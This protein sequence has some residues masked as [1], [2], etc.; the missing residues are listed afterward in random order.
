VSSSGQPSRITSGSATAEVLSD[1][2]PRRADLRL[3]V[4]ALVAWAAAAALLS[5]PASWVAVVVALLTGAALWLLRPSR[6]ARLGRPRAR[7]SGGAGVP[8]MLVATALVLVS[9]V[10]HR[11]LRTAGPVVD[12][13][14]QGASVTLRAEVVSDPRLLPARGVRRTPLVIVGLQVDQIVGR[15]NR[16]R[17]SAPVLAF[18]DPSWLGLQ[19]GEQVEVRGRLAPAQPG[20]DVVATLNGKGSPVV[21]AP[22]SAMKRAAGRLRAGLR[23][24]VRGTPS[25]GAG[26]LPGL[27]VGDT[28]GL[29]PGL[30][31][32]MRSSGLTHL[33]AVS[34]SNVAIVCGSAL[35]LAQRLGLPRRL[36]PPLA[37]LTLVGFVIVARPEPSVLRAAVMGGIGL[38]GLATARGRHGVPAL[39]AAIIALLVVDPWLA[40]SY[41]FALSSLATLGLLLFARPWGEAL[42]RWLPRPVAFAVAVPL[43]A[44][45]ACGPVIVLLQ[46]SV[47][48]VSVPANLVV[49]PLVAPATIAGV[50]AAASSL[51]SSHLAHLIAWLGVL[52]A[53]GMAAVARQAQRVP[54]VPWPG[55]A[56][57]AMSLALLTAMAVIGAGPAARACLRHPWAAAAFAPVLVAGVW[58]TSAPGWPPPGW[59]MV[60]CD[61][62]QGDGLVLNTGPQHA[63]V[64]DTGP[65]PAPM[66]A[67]LRRLEIS[68]VDLLVLTHDHSDH[69][70]GVPGVLH[71]RRVGELLI[72]GL[73][74]PPA[75]AR[76]I[77]GWAARAR[78]PV[79]QAH[80]GEVGS[81]GGV[82]WQVL[83]PL[84]VIHE[85]SVP[86]NDSVVLLVRSYGLRLLLLGDVETPAA[87]Q[88]DLALRA[89]PGGPHVDVLKV[90]HHGSALQDPGLV[91]DAGARLALI[92]VG[93]GNPYGHPAPSTVNL[94]RATGAT[95]RRTDQDGD[96]AVVSTGGRLSALTRPP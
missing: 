90:A 28:S 73:D 89:V 11:G 49:A 20:D 12:L 45:A 72:N 96:I 38:V 9:M 56:A 55:G 40:R 37:A 5:V 69:V 88:V 51:L 44:Q 27:V 71:G 86:N 66:D 64:V 1:D 83:W 95:V 7:T 81:I 79:R 41:G 84:Y 54:A 13:A 77:A 70:E 31:Q 46:G 26:L 14:Q 48:L 61:V 67:C 93:A 34:G 42:A 82:Q 29:D 21:R 32:A 6:P 35:F 57:G 2:E 30:E 58:P 85:G 74:D 62:G 87:R 91:H 59:V 10:L 76:R 63:I 17:V 23:D 16:S 94:L 53:E 80:V 8:L 3:L 25:D 50:L 24:A 19:W 78:L 47:S 68:V 18:A 33:V 43:A 75:E 60:M 65:D 22:P 92:S 36:R 52:P 4:P 39:S 15:G